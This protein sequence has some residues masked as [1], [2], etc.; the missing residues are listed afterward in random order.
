MTPHTLVRLVHRRHL[1]CDETLRLLMRSFLMTLWD[2]AE[3]GTMD[4]DL[5]LSEQYDDDVL[6]RFD[7]D[8]S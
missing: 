7:A 1:F 8:T 3:R 6:E 4:V 2:T 5:S